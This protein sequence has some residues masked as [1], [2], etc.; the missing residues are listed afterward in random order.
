MKI[1]RDTVTRILAENGFSLGSDGDPTYDLI[2]LGNINVGVLYDAHMYLA[3]E[4]DG[5]RD[6][7]E[8][9][10]T[11]A[12]SRIMGHINALKHPVET[13]IRKKRVNKIRQ[14]FETMKTKAKLSADLDSVSDIVDAVT[15]AL[16]EL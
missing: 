1:T 10:E 4:L 5:L 11:Y 13:E 8:F 2:W 9:N 7:I 3:K 15:A 14:Y 12:L 16:E 6:L